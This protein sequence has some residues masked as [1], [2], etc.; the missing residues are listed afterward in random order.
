M[1]V[2][3]FAK[4]WLNPDLPLAHR[5]FVGGCLVVAAHLIE[6]LDVQ[7]ALDLAPLAALGAS[8]LHGAGVAGRRRGP[9][10]HRALGVFCLPAAE[11]VILGA[12]I[13]VAFGIVR[14]LRG[15]I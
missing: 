12:A 5:P 8:G 4:E 6:V 1:P 15:T 13:F 3:G 11:R 10:D 7:R 14:E 9:I 2:L